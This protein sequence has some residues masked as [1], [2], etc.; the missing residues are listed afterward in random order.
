MKFKI[1]L[2][3]DGVIFLHPNLFTLYRNS[4]WHYNLNNIC[5]RAFLREFLNTGCLG[6]GLREFNT[7]DIDLLA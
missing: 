1:W 4:I 3:T 5:A 7:F 6:V 2:A